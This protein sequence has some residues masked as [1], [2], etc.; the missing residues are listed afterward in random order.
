MAILM[1]FMCIGH[2]FRGNAALEQEFQ[3]ALRLLSAF[4]NDSAHHVLCGILDELS[5]SNELNTPFGLQVRLRDAE[6]LEKEHQDEKAIKQLL[7]LVEDARNHRQWDVLSNAHLSLA[8]LHEKMDRMKPCQQALKR[9]ARF[10]KMHKLANIYPRL[11]IR[12]SSYYRLFGKKEFGHVFCTGSN[13]NSSQ[14][15]SV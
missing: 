13:S 14:S 10:I 9:A 3:Y 4:K 8:R 2:G 1:P 12:Q 15:R 7:L 5:Q 11:C 6:A